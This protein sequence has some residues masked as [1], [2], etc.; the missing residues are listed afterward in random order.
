MNYLREEVLEGLAQRYVVGTMSYRARRRFA[1]VL[2]DEP[3]ARDKVLAWEERLSPLAL[4]MDPVHPSQ[5]L[6]CPK[7]TPSVLHS[8]LWKIPLL[9]WWHSF[10]RLLITTAV[11]LNFK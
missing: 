11:Q 3:T 2:Y 6:R 9:S 10:I 7:R 4:S 1:Q 5:L 8:I